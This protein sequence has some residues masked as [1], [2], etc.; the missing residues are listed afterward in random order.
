MDDILKSIDGLL[1][2]LTLEQQL[3]KLKELKSDIEIRI[4]FVEEQLED[5]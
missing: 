5:K 1:G 3:E 2:I 4:E